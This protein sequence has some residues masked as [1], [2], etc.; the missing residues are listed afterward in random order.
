MLQV[1]GKYGNVMNA[2]QLYIY[3]NKPKDGLFYFVVEI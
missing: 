3:L 1:K 2:I